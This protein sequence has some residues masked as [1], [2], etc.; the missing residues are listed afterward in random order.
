LEIASVIAASLDETADAITKP[1]LSPSDA[2]E[3][4]SF[5][6][7]ESI[8]RGDLQG[9][10]DRALSRAA[11]LRFDEVDDEPTDWKRTGIVIA[12]LVAV[13]AIPGA[14]LGLWSGNGGT[15]EAQPRR[16]ET[17]SRSH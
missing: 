6:R 11:E 3:P 16:R 2:L 9:I 13:A 8:S 17:P 14:V 5:S 4:E 10:A 12:A 7:P 15:D 1:G